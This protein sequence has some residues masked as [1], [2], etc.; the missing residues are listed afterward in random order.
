MR[1]PHGHSALCTCPIC[2][3]QS[4]HDVDHSYEANVRGRPSI[5]GARDSGWISSAHRSSRPLF[6]EVK[7]TSQCND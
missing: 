1:R 3:R 7:N 5:L 4:R 6:A 2:R